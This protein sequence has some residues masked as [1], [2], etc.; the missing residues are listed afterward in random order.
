MKGGTVDYEK[1]SANH[2][3]EKTFESRVDEDLSKP[4]GE[5]TSQAYSLH[6]YVSGKEEHD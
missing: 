4:D 1:L 6:A 3:S 5:E 2:T